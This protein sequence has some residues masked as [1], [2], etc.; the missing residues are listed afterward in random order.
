MI[1]R[2]L[3][4]AGLAGADELTGVLL[5]DGPGSFTGL[6]VSASVA[7]AMVLTRRLQLRT[8]P[9][10]LVLAAGALPS[11]TGPVLTVIDAL[12]GELYGAIYELRDGKV[13][14]HLA[15]TVGTPDALIALATPFA[16]RAVTGQA[17]EPVLVHL[18]QALGAARLVA[19][20]AGAPVLLS[21]LAVGDALE[22]I[23]DVRRW[24]PTYGRPAEAQRKW[25]ETHGR[26]L[27]PA[28]GDGG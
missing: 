19:P 13:L 10:L 18:H 23:V 9:S 6:R 15:P 24:E 7:K 25:E 5:A 28:T 14:T 16:P 27:P 20:P 11:P 1:D 2:M 4:E 22:P 21:L 12:R 3:T 8:A 17:T 26:P